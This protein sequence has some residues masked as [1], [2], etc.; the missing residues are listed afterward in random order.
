MFANTLILVTF[1]A[2]SA[3]TI[4]AM[5]LNMFEDGS[6]MQGFNED[7]KKFN[8]HME[9]VKDEMNKVAVKMKHDKQVLETRI[10]EIQSMNATD[11]TKMIRVNETDSVSVYNFGGCYCMNLECECCGIVDKLSEEP[12]CFKMSYARA[13]M[14]VPILHSNVTL[15]SLSVF[16]IK[17]I[18]ADKFCLHFYNIIHKISGLKGCVDLKVVDTDVQVRIGCFR[19]EEHNQMFNRNLMSVRNGNETVFYNQMNQWVNTDKM[20]GVDMGTF[21]NFNKFGSFSSLIMNVNVDVE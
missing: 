1:L 21:I 10:E 7:M 8:Q 19:M 17:D 13:E 16:D 3:T 6:F 5:N 11:L 15:G 14:N 9:M 4:N 18:C 12:E 20:E 2:V